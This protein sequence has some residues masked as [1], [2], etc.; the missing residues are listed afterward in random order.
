MIPKSTTKLS[1]GD[2]CLILRDDGM[3]VPFVF[4]Q[5]V[6]GKRSYFYGALVSP[7]LPSATSVIP[8]RL[9]V[10]G[11]AMLHIKCFKENNTPI[12]GN[13]AGEIGDAALA[14][15]QRACTD[16][17]VGAVHGVWGNRTI[18]R[19]ANEMEA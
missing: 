19:R 10:A 1:T 15:A 16:M 9:T 17:S 3:A 4:L 6:P 5:A 14:T 7:P 13:V 11:Q 12:V 8:E 2:Y 18:I